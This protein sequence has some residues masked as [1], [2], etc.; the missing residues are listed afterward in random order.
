M[1][2]T[3]S[4]AE[5]LLETIQKSCPELKGLKLQNA[6]ARLG[7]KVALVSEGESG[8]LNVKTDFITYSEMFYFL[9]GYICK[10]E[11]RI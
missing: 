11:N 2:I 3:K 9:Q 1:K 10:T 5:H 8:S 6:D 7:K 4:A